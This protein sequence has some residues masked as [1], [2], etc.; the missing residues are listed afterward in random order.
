MSNVASVIH[1]DSDVATM[2]GDDGITYAVLLNITGVFGLQPYVGGTFPQPFVNKSGA[3]SSAALDVVKLVVSAPAATYYLNNGIS[4]GYNTL[5]DYDILIRVTKGATITLSIDNQDYVM[6]KG[7]A[8]DA[9]LN[10]FDGIWVAG[11]FSASAY[12]TY[13]IQTGGGVRQWI[14]SGFTE[15]VLKG[16]AEK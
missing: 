9:S 4:L 8:A 3:A 14:W 13:I 12:E 5:V 6:F 2:D 1:I 15:N 10:A 11:V 7:G 16:G